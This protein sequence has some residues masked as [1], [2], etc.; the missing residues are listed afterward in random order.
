MKNIQYVQ[1][2]KMAALR[3]IGFLLVVFY[4]EVDFSD[5][6]NTIYTKLFNMPYIFSVENIKKII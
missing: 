6:S 4:S 1:F 5:I 3:E 2:F